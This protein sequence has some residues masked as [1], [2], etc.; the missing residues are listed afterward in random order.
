MRISDWSSDVCSSDLELVA[1][2][3]NLVNR[4]AS[5]IAK[6][7]GQI[8]TAGRLE[9]V[10]EALLD[11]VRG[12]FATVGGLIERQRFRQGIGEVLRVVGEANRYV[13]ETEPF[14]LKGE[15]IGRAHV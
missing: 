6:N 9:P 8:P 13:A 11:T 1:G 7:F 4:T 2:W 10:D 3:G 5:M 14:K 12:A 15:E